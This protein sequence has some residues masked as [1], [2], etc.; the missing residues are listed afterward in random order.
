MDLKLLIPKHD[1]VLSTHN[2]VMEFSES[3]TLPD[4]IAAGVSQD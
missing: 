4:R 1:E 3:Q 2:L